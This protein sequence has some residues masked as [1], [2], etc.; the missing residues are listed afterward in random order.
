MT[1]FISIWIIKMESRLLFIKFQTE[2]I[3]KQICVIMIF[4]PGVHLHVFLLEALFSARVKIVLLVRAQ[5]TTCILYK[6]LIYWSW[7]YGMF[8]ISFSFRLNQLETIVFFKV[9]SPFTRQKPWQQHPFLHVQRCVDPF[10]AKLVL[11]SAVLAAEVSVD[12]CR[13]MAAG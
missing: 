1:H 7:L 13:C 3:T 8:V 5:N 2:S 12:V 10:V 9:H 11:A 6:S 4:I